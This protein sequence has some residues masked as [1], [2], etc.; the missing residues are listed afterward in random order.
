MPYVITIESNVAPSI[1]MIE[2]ALGSYR[3][4]Q[5]YSKTACEVNLQYGVNYYLKTLVPAMG[6][7]RA[8]FEKEEITDAPLGHRL[9]RLCTQ[10]KPNRSDNTFEPKYTLP[11]TKEAM[12]TCTSVLQALVKHRYLTASEVTELFDLAI[13]PHGLFAQKALLL[14]NGEIVIHSMNM[15]DASPSS[16][17][18]KAKRSPKRVTFHVNTGSQT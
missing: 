7:L 10:Y 17:N 5:I 8:S 6:I 11:H 14:V 1:S 4:E 15:K 12:A 9:L 2:I 13:D 16:F 3:I 18:F